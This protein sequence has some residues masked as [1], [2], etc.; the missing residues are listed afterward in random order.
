MQ[1]T[2]AIALIVELAINKLLYAEND[3]HQVK[4]ARSRL[5][6][7]VLQ[8]EIES[9]SQPLIIVFSPRQVDVLSLWSGDIDCTVKAPL[10]V[11]LTLRKRKDI[12][13]LIRSHQLHVEG[14]TDVLQRLI[15]LIE[16]VDWDVADTLS[17]LVGDAAAY[18]ISHHLHSLSAFAVNV[19]NKQENNFKDAVKEEWLMLPNP[20]ELAYLSDGIAELARDVD[21]I[22]NRLEK[23]NSDDEAR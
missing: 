2:L 17:P 15:A 12:A 19:F 14:D 13:E 9:L 5:N 18:G 10:K 20:L 8:V 11:F 23:L 4:S 16:L 7:K 21:A 1:P 22:A 6:E 3:D